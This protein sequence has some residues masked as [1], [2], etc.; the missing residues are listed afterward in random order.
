LAGFQVITYGRFWVFTEE[1]GA[2]RA[3]R[4]KRDSALWRPSLSVDSHTFREVPMRR[5]SHVSGT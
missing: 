5:D 4:Q 1:H 3:M 2:A